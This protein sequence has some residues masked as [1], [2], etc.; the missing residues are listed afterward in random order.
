MKDH[1]NTYT[2]AHY[3]LNKKILSL[4]LVDVIPSNNYL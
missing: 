1:K 2:M 4:E 3:D